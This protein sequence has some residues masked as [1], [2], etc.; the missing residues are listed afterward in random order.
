M[1]TRT[2]ALGALAI[3]TAQAGLPANAQGAADTAASIEER[4]EIYRN[5]DDRAALLL[6][7][8]RLLD[9]F[10]EDPCV[11]V[12]VALLGGNPVAELTEE[13]Y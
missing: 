11:D 7:L 13:P 6:E 12:I 8:E 9:E 5:I 10:P 4:C 1:K 3:L 2:S